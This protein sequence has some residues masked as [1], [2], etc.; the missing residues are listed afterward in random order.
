LSDLPP[1]E[2]NVTIPDFHNVRKRFEIFQKVVD[3]DTYNRTI[4]VKPEINLAHKYWDVVKDT[5]ALIESGQIP[6]RI[7]HNDTK[8]NNVLLDKDNSTGLCVIDLDTVMGGTVLF[9]FGD[10]VRTCVSLS[11]EDEV[12]LSRVSVRIPIFTALAEGWLTPMGKTLTMIEKENLISASKL[13]VYEQAIRFLSDYISGDKYYK[14]TREKHNIDR[15]KTQFALLDSIIKNED[16]M[17][18]II[19]SQL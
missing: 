12:D 1:L 10:M 5:A 13:I 4:N 17:V 14:I 11:D 19:E 6:E 2:L 8:F 3:D 15:C 16:E 7:A 18:E 9:D